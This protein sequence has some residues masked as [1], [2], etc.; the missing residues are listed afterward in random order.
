[1]RAAVFKGKNKIDIESVPM[2][3]L[4]DEDVLIKVMACGICGTD[5]H[6]YNGEEGAA[7]TNPPIILGHEFSGIIEHK[8]KNVVDI[9]TGDRVTVD[10]NN[11]C[12]KCYYCKNKMAQFCS[13]M[14]GYGT[15]KNGGVC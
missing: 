5:I 11:M 1:M 2:P 8:G 15:T 3:K 6:I 9:D 4:G 12:G 14:I 10:P 13:N 7:A